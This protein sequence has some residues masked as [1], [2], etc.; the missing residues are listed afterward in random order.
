[1]DLPLITLTIVTSVIIFL[2]NLTSSSI[3]SYYFLVIIICG[4]QSILT[5][6]I[7]FKSSAIMLLFR[8][9]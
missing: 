2:F 1:M 9:I 6:V 7:P 4:K 8:N 3:S 5:E